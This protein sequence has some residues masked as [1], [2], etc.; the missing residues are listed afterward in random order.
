VPNDP[1][2]FKE[3][4]DVTSVTKP[5]YNV[6]DPTGHLWKRITFDEANITV[7]LHDANRHSD[8]T[9][10]KGIAQEKDAMADVPSP[11]SEIQV[12]IQDVAAGETLTALCTQSTRTSR[13]LCARRRGEGGRVLALRRAICGEGAGTQVAR[14]QRGDHDRGRR[15]GIECQPRPRRERVVGQ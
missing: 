10:P 12:Y 14:G 5:V 2:I 8:F 11:T 4:R 15:T 1:R 6:Y 13:R 9:P 7:Q 3:A